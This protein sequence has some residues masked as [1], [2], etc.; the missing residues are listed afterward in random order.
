M[1]TSLTSFASGSGGG[2][3]EEIIQDDDMTKI[4][5]LVSLHN[6]NLFVRL[7][8]IR[9]LKILDQEDAMDRKCKHCHKEELESEIK[10]GNLQ[11]KERKILSM[12]LQAKF[13]NDQKT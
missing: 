9:K 4:L 3:P 8:Q 10:M 12:Q 11:T 1:S 13:Q 7:N 5:M 2:A 6:T